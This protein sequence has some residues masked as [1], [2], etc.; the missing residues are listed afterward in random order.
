MKKLT[1]TEAQAQGY[2]HFAPES[3]FTDGEAKIFEI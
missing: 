3:M 2:T 1:I